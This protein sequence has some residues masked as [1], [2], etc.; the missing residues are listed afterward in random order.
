MLL[1]GSSFLCYC[2]LRFEGRNWS[3]SP[4][5]SMENNACSSSVWGY[6]TLVAI[7]L[8]VPSH[9]ATHSWLAV[10][11]A[12]KSVHLTQKLYGK[13]QTTPVGPKKGTTLALPLFH[14]SI[15]QV[16][17]LG[18]FLALWVPLFYT[19][20][21]KTIYQSELAICIAAAK[22]KKTCDALGMRLDQ[23]KWCHTSC[24]VGRF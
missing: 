20:C 4:W 19:R 5:L 10:V 14:P 24:M 2:R 16:L 11:S 22:K 8:A 3:V 18:W 6:L 13:C 7:T 17:I 1:P 9:D 21:S 23:A 15:F 12:E